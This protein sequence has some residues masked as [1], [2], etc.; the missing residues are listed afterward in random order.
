LYYKEHIS[1]NTMMILKRIFHKLCRI[2]NIK[3]EIRHYLGPLLLSKKHINDV[4][5]LF[6]RHTKDELVI[7]EIFDEDSYMFNKLG[8]RE[9][10]IVIDIGAHIGCFTVRAAKIAKK[11]K[12]Y[13]FEP[14][15][16]NFSILKKNVKINKLSNVFY[17]REAA[18]DSKRIVELFIP[19]MHQWKQTGQHSI[20]KIEG[21]H[22]NRCLKTHGVSLKSILSDNNIK[23]VDLLKLDCEGGEYQ[24]LYSA[25][26][27][28]LDSFTR[29]IMEYHLFENADQ[30]KELKAYLQKNGFK[31]LEVISHT[32]HPKL[33]LAYF[34]K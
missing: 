9:D 31:A 33:G 14:E 25:P 27:K 15:P 22:Q 10:S 28:V 16:Q 17:F 21:L 18:S 19:Y 12:V 13:C 4:I 1:I 11:G 26:R 29:I 20:V 5:I 3:D 30:F 2:L 24:I 7:E 23:K 32:K 6:R 34:V 8:L